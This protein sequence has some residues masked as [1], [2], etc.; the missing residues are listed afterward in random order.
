MIAQSSTPDF[1]APSQRADF[2]S[3]ALIF[4]VR[5]RIRPCEFAF[6]RR[7]RRRKRRRGSAVFLGVEFGLTLRLAAPAKFPERDCPSS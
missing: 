7:P 1:W 5:E 3:T 6:L 2:A 4:S